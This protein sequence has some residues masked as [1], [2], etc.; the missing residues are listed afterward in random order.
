MQQQG[1]TVQLAQGL[2]RTGTETRAEAGGRNEDRDV[3]TQGV[4]RGHVAVLGL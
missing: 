2:G 3:T 4:L 1:N